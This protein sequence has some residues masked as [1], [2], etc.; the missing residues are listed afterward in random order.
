MSEY[1]GGVRWGQSLFRCG[2]VSY[3]LG[4]LIIDSDQIIIRVPGSEFV[5]DRNDIQKIGV[6][7]RIFYKGLVF[8]HSNTNLPK[9]LVFWTF[10]S[11]LILRNLNSL[12]SE[13]ASK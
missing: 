9:I 1:K 3:P 11:D 7:N 12:F 6:K 4:G 2:N 10:Q 8:E 5:L 13:V